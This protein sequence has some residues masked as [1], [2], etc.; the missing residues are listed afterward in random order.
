MYDN[1]NFIV[2]YAG[3]IIPAAHKPDPTYLYNAYIGNRYHVGFNGGLNIQVRLNKD[4]CGPLWAWF[5]MLDG[6]Y[7]F[8][9]TQCRTLD[10]H[11]KPWSRFLLLT[12]PCEPGVATPGVNVLTREMHVR[13]YGIYNFASGFRFKNGWYEIEIG[14]NLWGHPEEFIAMENRFFTEYGI[15]GVSADPT[16]AASASASTIRNQSAS[17]STFVKI[18]ESD[19]NVY[20]GSAGSALNHTFMVGFGIHETCSYLEW[21]FGGGIYTEIAHMNR[22]VPTWGGWVKVGASF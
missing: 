19:I 4:T 15:L 10:L 11:H 16:V 6:N 18:K 7:L 14:Y 13:P 8:K 5:V 20:S 17:D 3:L 1:D 9:N 22:P 21:T 2:Y 12:Q